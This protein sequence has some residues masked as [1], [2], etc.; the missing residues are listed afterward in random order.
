[1]KYMSASL[2]LAALLLSGCVSDPS[3]EVAL[4]QTKYHVVIPP[5]AL[6][7]CDLTRLPTSFLSNKDVAREF[8]KLYNNNVKCHNNAR[9][10]KVFLEKAKQTLGE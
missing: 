4:I 5:E 1:M 9:A 6:M 7:E 3:P 8:V 2:I 10:V